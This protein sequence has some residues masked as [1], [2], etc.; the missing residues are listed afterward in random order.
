MECADG[1]DETIGP[2][3]PRFRVHRGDATGPSLRA[4][5]LGRDAEATT[6]CRGEG[7]IDV[8]A[9]DTDDDHTLDEFRP[10]PNDVPRYV[11][12]TAP[13]MRNRLHGTDASV[14]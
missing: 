12:A 7:A 6:D 9:G 8:C 2:E 3:A 11:L 10:S 14:R 4:E 13:L 5:E 1:A